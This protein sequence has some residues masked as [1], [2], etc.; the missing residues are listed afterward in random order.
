MANTDST[1]DYKKFDYEGWCYKTLPIG[2]L[3]TII[4]AVRSCYIADRMQGLGGS[5]TVVD[6][7]KAFFRTG[8]LGLLF[9]VIIWLG[10]II[11]MFIMETRH[12][13]SVKAAKQQQEKENL[14]EK[15]RV[16][17]ETEE[18]AQQE[19]RKH[20][21]VINCPLCN[22]NGQCVITE[23]T[24]RIYD[25]RW[26]LD[27]WIGTARDGYISD[28][29]MDKSVCE[30]TEP[31]PGC[32]GEGIAYAY[33][34]IGKR[35][36]CENCH[37]TGRVMVE[38]IIKKEIGAERKNEEV[39]CYKCGGRGYNAMDVVHVRTLHEPELGRFF[40]D[41]P[42][43]KKRQMREASQFTVLLT[44]TNRPFYSKTKPRF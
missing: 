42:D 16:C 39:P 21:R 27:R 24:D 18:R 44:D 17:K 15:E 33:F 25:G 43:E 29:S 32:K 3:L 41:E 36:T 23:Y 22:G 12:N 37:G 40:D 26:R 13:A 5:G 10:G 9:T 4:L 38:R 14:L 11:Y 19:D 34:E 7:F 2:L 1:N 35:E 28:D 30:R 8:G 31:C 6:A 20:D